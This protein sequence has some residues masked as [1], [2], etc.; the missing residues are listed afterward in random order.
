MKEGQL[1]DKKEVIEFC[2]RHLASYKKPKE[3]AFIPAIP[4]NPSGKA[5]KRLLVKA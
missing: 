4:R 3:V 5:L 2:R 1:V